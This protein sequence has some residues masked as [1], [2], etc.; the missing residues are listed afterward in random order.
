VS[1]RWTR[2]ILGALLLEVVLLITL[3]PLS[4]IA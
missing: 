2:V 3:V 1:I 4:L